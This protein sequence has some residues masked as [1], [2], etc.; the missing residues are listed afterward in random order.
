MSLYAIWSN[1]Q[2][3][4]REE[5]TMSLYGMMKGKGSNGLGYTTTA[6]QVTKGIDLT[7][8]TFL[9]TGC[10]SGIGLETLRV[11]AM[12]GGHVLAVARTVEKAQAAIDRSGATGTALACDL[13]EPVSVRECI[14]AV[15]VLGRP[16]NGMICNAGIMALPKLQQKHGYEMQFFTNHIGHFILV[17]GLLE[18]L[19]GEG[20]VVMVASAAHHNA[21][22]K[23]IQF[24]N[25]DGSHGYS[26]WANYGQSK[27]ANILFARHLAKKLSGKGQT[28]NAIH[29]G[30]IHTNLTRHMNPAMRII[31]PLIGPLALKSIG[32]GAATQC[33]VATHPDLA[34][35]SGEYFRDCGKVF[36]SRLGQDLELAERLWNRSEEIVAQVG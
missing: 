33:Y 31:M 10:N 30:V 16:L 27:L 34:G 18:Q 8:N 1:Y 17:T 35:I 13:A 29:P 36:S 15:K 12:R 21:P 9:L 23:G 11:L 2:P 28:A 25:L 14:T 19:A 4:V 32:Q 3:L 6:E 20:R 7:G 5:L 26:P 22:D 24:D